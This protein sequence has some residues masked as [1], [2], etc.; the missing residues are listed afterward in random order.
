MLPPP[1]RFPAQKE[2]L[3]QPTGEVLRFIL[4]GHMIDIREFVRLPAIYE[5]LSSEPP[6]SAENFSE[7]TLRLGREILENAV[8]R[9]RANREGW[10]HRHQGTW[11]MMRTCSRS[12]LHLM[13]MALKCQQAAEVLHVDYQTLEQE[14]LPSN[15]REAVIQVIE[16]LDYWAEESQDLERLSSILKE[17]MHAYTVGL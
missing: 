13:G 10:Y 11:L 5:I 9:I 17:L 14:M 2:Q 8:D 3:D 16:L 6:F 15:W 4:R 7:T 1:V 12:A